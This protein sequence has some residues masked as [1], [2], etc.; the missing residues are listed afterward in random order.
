MNTDI[1]ARG[2]ALTDSLR[3]AVEREAEEFQRQL[4]RG[5]GPIS[6]RLFDTNGSA[7]GGADKVCLVHARVTGQRASLV[8]TAIDS[9]L[10]RAIVSAF[11]KLSRSART[12]AHRTRSLRR[13]SS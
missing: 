11:A 13:K 7:R 12:A 8:A 4:P 6:V 3:V 10:Y 5:N 2:F 1:C 9:D